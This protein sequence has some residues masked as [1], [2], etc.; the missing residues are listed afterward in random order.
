MALLVP[1]RQIATDAT[2]CGRSALAAKDPG[3]LLLHFHHAQ[4]PLRLIVRERDGQ[5]IEE[6]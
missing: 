4:I 6:G 5:I 2:K 1:G 3:N